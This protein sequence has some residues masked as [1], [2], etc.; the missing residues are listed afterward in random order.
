MTPNILRNRDTTRRRVWLGVVLAAIGLGLAVHEIGFGLP[1]TARDITGDA[2]WAL[3]MFAWLGVFW[4]RG[5]L[6]DRALVAVAICWAVELSQI[7]HT[8]QLDALR[9]TMLG[10]LLLGTGFDPRDLAAY[11]LG[12]LVGG[13]LEHVLEERTI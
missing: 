12:V 11:A 2:L 8:P 5:S 9:Q 1:S 3:M 13:S 6:R 7:Y 10:Q 4:P